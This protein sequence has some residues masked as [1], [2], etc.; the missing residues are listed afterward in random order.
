MVNMKS[1]V[2][3]YHSSSQWQD[4]IENYQIDNHMEQL[5]L[6]GDVITRW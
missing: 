3:K 4:L 6:I 5:K 2:T 1:Y